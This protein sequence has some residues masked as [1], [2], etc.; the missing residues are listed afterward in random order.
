MAQT[1]ANRTLNEIK[2]SLSSNT[3]ELLTDPHLKN[4]EA[5]RVCA[6]ISDRVTDGLKESKNLSTVFE[7]NVILAAKGKES[8]EW[9]IIEKS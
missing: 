8:M 1:V 9:S 3:E 5:S 4:H 2:I 6:E 7:K